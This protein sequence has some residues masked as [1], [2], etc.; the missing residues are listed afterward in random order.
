MGS[1]PLPGANLGSDGFDLLVICA[2][3]RVHFLGNPSE[4]ETSELFRCPTL[5]RQCLWP[6]LRINPCFLKQIH[7]VGQ[8]PNGITQ[9]FALLPEADFGQFEDFFDRLCVRE[10]LRVR[11]D[12]Q[13]C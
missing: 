8:L 12:V 10:R 6:P 9:H 2:I 1:F 3:E 11:F 13:H 5:H 4:R 7:P